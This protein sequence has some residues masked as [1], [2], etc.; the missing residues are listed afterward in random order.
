MKLP[1][2]ETHTSVE[3]DGG[4]ILSKKDDIAL[5]VCTVYFRRLVGK[6]ISLIIRRRF[7]RGIRRE[8]A[9]VG[10]QMGDFVVRL[11]AEIGGVVARFGA[12]G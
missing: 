8:W 12:W 5:L 1:R 11:V 2:H 6:V 9:V 4:F 3:L 7:P 10:A